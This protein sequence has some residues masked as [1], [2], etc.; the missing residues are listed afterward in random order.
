[1]WAVVNFHAQLH[2]DD[3]GPKAKV[4]NIKYKK[5]VVIIMVVV[6]V[7]VNAKRQAMPRKKV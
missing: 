7:V 4:C 3:R 1:M 6:V 2:S 5:R